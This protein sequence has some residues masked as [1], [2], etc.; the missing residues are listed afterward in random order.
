[1][2]KLLYTVCSAN[3]LGYA[4]TMAAS[5]AAHHPDY[6]IIMVLIDKIEGRFAIADLL[7][8][9]ILEIDRLAIPGFSEMATQY[10]VLELNCAMKP[11]VA[12]YLFENEQPDLLLYIDSDTWIFNRFTAIEAAME[13]ADILITPHFTSPYPDNTQLP[14]ERDVLSSGIYNAGFIAMKKSENTAQFLAWWAMHMKN[15][16]YYNFAEGMGVDQVWL[17][18]VPLLFNKVLVFE[19]PGANMAYWNFHERNLSHQNGNIVVNNIFPLLFLHISGYSFNEPDSFSRHQNRFS[20]NVFPLLTQLLKNYRDLVMQNG[21]EIY[22][23]L[24]C[25]YA[26]KKKKS[27]GIMRTINKLLKPLGIKVTDC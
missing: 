18:L 2:K 22:T 25:A 9:R 4:K 27:L 6:T 26:I 21:H 24:T 19:N 3:H 23:G 8:H 11:F 17:N 1:M 14:T 16:C 10:S 7:P 20:N 13:Y 5:F 12:Q 15:E